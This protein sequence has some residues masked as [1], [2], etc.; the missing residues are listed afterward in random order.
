MWG[1]FAEWLPSGL[2]LFCTFL[3]FFIP[4]IIHK[5]SRKLY[6]N[7]NPPW[8]KEEQQKASPSYPGKSE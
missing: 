1:T 3:A 8:K 2:G 4:F 5:I 6:Q 7:S